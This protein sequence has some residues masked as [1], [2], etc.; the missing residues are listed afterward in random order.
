MIFNFY[1]RQEMRTQTPHI[2]THGYIFQSCS[3]SICVYIFSSFKLNIQ[4]TATTTLK[5]PFYL[6][7]ESMLTHKTI[8]VIVSAVLML[9]YK[10]YHCINTSGNNK[11]GNNKIGLINKILG[12]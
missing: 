11:I 4:L 8:N 2:H 12:H 1:P 7:G 9:L 6:C 5:T 3:L 10:N